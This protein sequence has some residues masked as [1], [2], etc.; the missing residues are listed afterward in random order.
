GDGEVN[1]Q[2]RIQMDLF[3]ARARAEEEYRAALGRSGLQEAALS[4]KLKRR[5]KALH[6]PPHVVAG[7]AANQVLELAGIGEWKA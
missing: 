6:H 1:V 3:K 2:S 7:T 4:K 5:A